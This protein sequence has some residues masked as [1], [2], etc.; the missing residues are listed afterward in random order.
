ML[1][2]WW[3]F[4]VLTACNNV[5]TAKNII[6]NSVKA[7]GGEILDAV[8]ISFDFRNIH[9]ILKQKD[10]WYQYS[11]IFTDSLGRRIADHLNNQQLVRT[12]NGDTIQL[13]Q[14]SSEKYQSSIN[15]VAYFFLLPYKLLDQ[16]VNATYLGQDSLG[17]HSYHKIKVTFDSQGGGKDYQDEFIYWF[18]TE[19]HTL[20]YIAYTYETDGG[21][22]RFRKAINSRIINGIRVNDYLNYKPEDESIP[23]ESIGNLFKEGKLELLSEIINNNIEV[24]RI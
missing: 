10:G 13:D 14:K 16:A 21:G 24:N 20:D 5:P 8:E 15:S 9:Y 12:I 17:N 1:K 22:I 11:R 18:E 19:L 3:I 2:Y 7:H 6:E 23:L 4:F